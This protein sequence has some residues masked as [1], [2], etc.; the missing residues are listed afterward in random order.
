MSYFP[1]YNTILNL[2]KTPEFLEFEQN[3]RCQNWIYIKKIF[4]SS[5]NE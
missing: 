4:D 5:K 3:C 2:Q 1:K